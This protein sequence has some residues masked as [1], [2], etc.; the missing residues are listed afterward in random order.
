MQPKRIPALDGL[1]GFSIA[2]VVAGHWLEPRLVGWERD[3][4]G[5]A[6]SLGV[7][8]FFVLSGYL[9]T[10]LLL[11]ERAQ[12]GSIDLRAFYR[13]RARRILPAST[14]FMLTAFVLFRPQLSWGHALAAAFYVTNFDPGHP[15]FLGH[16]W[17][18]SVEEQ[19]YAIWP[20]A[21]KKWRTHS[22][23]FCWRPCSSP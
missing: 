18:L 3:M 17:S 20:A 13:R 6:A 10:R 9:I 8:I 16:L 4:A 2:L 14:C 12:K 11:Q 7:R 15:W 21:L 1:R 19:F 22:S 23:R 5:T